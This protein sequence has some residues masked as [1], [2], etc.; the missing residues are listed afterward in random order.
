MFYREAAMKKHEY[1]QARVAIPIAL[2]IPKPWK[3]IKAR[4]TQNKYEAMRSIR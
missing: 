2:E 1:P 3:I 4:A